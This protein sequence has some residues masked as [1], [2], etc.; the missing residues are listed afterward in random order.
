MTRVHQGRSNTRNSNDCLNGILMAGL[1][2]KI[3]DAEF[4]KLVGEVADRMVNKRQVME[5]IAEIGED[6]I[7]TNF[8]A[9]GR[10]TKWAPLKRRDGQPLRDKDRLMNS[11][12]HQIDGNTVLIGT[13]AVYAAVHNFGAKKGS[14][15]SFV[16][17]VKEHGR[18]TKSGKSSKVRAHTRSVRLPWGDIPARE[19]M[20]LQSEDVIEIQGLL[21]D[22]IME[23]RSK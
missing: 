19:F 8:D 10:P 6:S 5:D 9:G 18:K 3:N 1:V 20:L 11:F 14:F 2:Y 7:R 17:K 23:G 12:G 16:A 22:W 13:N 4:Q 15:G 21:V